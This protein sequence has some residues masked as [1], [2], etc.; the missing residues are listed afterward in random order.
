VGSNRD[1]TALAAYRSALPLLAR[2]P[3]TGAELTD[4]LSERGLEA[5]AVEQA[6]ERLRE[7]GYI[8][9][10]KLALHY[11]LARSERLGHGASRLLRELE[12]RGVEKETAR[13]AWDEAVLEHGLAEDELLRREVRRRVDR[14]GGRLD[15][16]GFRRVYNALLRAGFDPHAVRSELEEFSSFSELSDDG[17]D[18]DLA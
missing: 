17:I 1:N 3:L 11:I 8:D 14:S 6:V 7:E 13:S 10:R 9:D 2:K 16:A 12:R 18:N 4:A 15:L 5:G